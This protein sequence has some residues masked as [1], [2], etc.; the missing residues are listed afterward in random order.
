M[1]KLNKNVQSEEKKSKTIEEER[2]VVY[3]GH[4]PHGFYEKEMNNYFSQ[5]GEVTNINI[6]KSKVVFHIYIL[7]YR[8]FVK[9]FY[10]Y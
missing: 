4:I 9:Y 10:I 1:I 5:F 7:V 3:L 8:Y 2:G 6:P